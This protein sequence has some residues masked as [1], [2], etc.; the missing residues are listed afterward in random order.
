[1]R[2]R[3]GRAASRARTISDSSGSAR[4]PR[5]VV[6]RIAR[7]EVDERG[8]ERHDDEH[9]QRRHREAL[10]D[11]SEQGRSAHQAARKAKGR[12]WPSGRIAG[13]MPLRAA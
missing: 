13:V 3:A 7:D 12:T 5:M 6:D 2:H 9:D 11:V 8:Q 10:E 4:G 1:M